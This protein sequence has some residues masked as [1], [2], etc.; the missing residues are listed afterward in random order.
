MRFDASHLNERERKMVEKLVEAS[1]AMEDVYWRQ[2]DPEAL[3]LYETTK[4]P[5]LKRMLMI[6]GSRYDLINENHNFIGS[7]PAPPGRNLY[8]SGLTRRADRRVR[9]AAPRPEG[10]NLQRLHRGAVEGQGTGR[11]SVFG[12]VQ[13]IHRTRGESTCARPPV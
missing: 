11:H 6:N 3:K 4:D 13:A 1:R 10:R 12:G 7:E 2:S 5:Q 8:P 9:Q